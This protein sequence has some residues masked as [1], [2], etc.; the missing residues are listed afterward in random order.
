MADINTPQ[1]KNTTTQDLLD[2][3]KK[4]DKSDRAKDAVDRIAN[5]R[6]KGSTS[7]LRPAPGEAASSPTTPSHTGLIP[8]SIQQNLPG[9]NI[10]INGGQS[11]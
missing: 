7:A 3:R 10:P 4:H 2:R 9:G 5:L 1:K 8:G 6:N 11:P